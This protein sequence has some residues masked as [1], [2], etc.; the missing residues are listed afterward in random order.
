[1]GA[2]EQ[3]LRP[4]GAV[5]RRWSQARRWPKK[6]R[7]RSGQKGPPGDVLSVLGAQLLDQLVQ[8]RQLP[9]VNQVEFLAGEKEAQK[10]REPGKSVSL[11]VLGQLLGQ[12]PLLLLVEKSPFRGKE[13]SAMLESEIWDAQQV[14]EQA[15]KVKE[16]LVLLLPS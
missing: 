6:K 10:L 16:G 12:P 2:A 3:R 14:T 8:R 7:K 1:M 4:L 9:P 13:T 11:H 15:P 5:R